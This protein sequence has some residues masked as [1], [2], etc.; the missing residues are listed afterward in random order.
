MIFQSNAQKDIPTD[1]GERMALADKYF[2]AKEYGK[3]FEIYL[4]LQNLQ[5]ND[6]S[7]NYHIGL[8]YYYSENHKADAISHLE[9]VL[10]YDTRER[11]NADVYYYLAHSYHYE[12]EFRKAIDHFNIYKQKVISKADIIPN[13]DRLIEISKNAILLRSQKS[14]KDLAIKLLDFP[15]N[16]SYNDFAPV[17][18][19]SHKEL[20]FSS[21][22]PS[23]TVNLILNHN[24]VFMS[25]QE[26]TGQYEMLRSIRKGVVWD[27]PKSY[28]FPYNYI[29]TETISSDG[30]KFIISAG[31]TEAKQQFYISKPRGGN[32]SI[33]KKLSRNINSKHIEKGICFAESG[34]AIYFS[35]NRPGGF[36]GFDIYKSE[37]RDGKWLQAENVGPSINTQYDEVSPF[38]AADNKTLFFSSNGHNTMGDLDIFTSELKKGDWTAPRNLGYSVNSTYND[39]DFVQTNDAVYSYFSSN[40]NGIEA[41]GGYDI[42]SIFNPPKEPVYTVV[43]GVMKAFKNGRRI[44]VTLEVLN[45]NDKKKRKLVYSPDDDEGSYFMLL[46]PNGKYII[47]ATVDGD[48]VKENTITIPENAIGYELNQTLIVKSIELLSS[49]IGKFITVADPSFKIKMKKDVN[50]E[51]DTDPRY[52][53]LVNLLAEITFRMDKE[54]YNRINELENLPEVEEISYK[55]FYNP[56]NKQME[57]IFENGTLDDLTKLGTPWIETQ[58]APIFFNKTGMSLAAKSQKMIFGYTVHYSEGK[59]LLEDVDK[60]DLDKIIKLLKKYSFL[61]VD[62]VWYSYEDGQGGQDG[63]E[64]PEKRLK[65][66]TQY[67]Q[68]KYINSQRIKAINGSK[69]NTNGASRPQDNLMKIDLRVY[70]KKQSNN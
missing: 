44:P 18:V 10:K 2:N 29:S 25:E 23:E 57:E 70:Q 34:N 16:S 7:L 66:I 8:C 64:A 17:I 6:P 41:T 69:L 68:K 21:N 30:R 48:L 36:G 14:K 20:Y 35:S 32:W 11:V 42:I 60:L 62:L 59:Y 49:D 52:D 53:P 13:T 67:L 43:Y 63:N 54:Q 24:V 33:P 40:R 37:L 58:T 51:T 50:T 19:N 45:F 26:K 4:S 61:D 12:Q 38:V 27:Y 28:K 22:R 47:S 1:V 39:A 5:L 9:Y 31:K 55:E 15:V 56:L 3:A 65:A 46:P